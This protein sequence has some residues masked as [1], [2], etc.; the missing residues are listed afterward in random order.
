MEVLYVCLDGGWG[1]DGSSD[2]GILIVIL[3]GSR[4]LEKRCFNG[5][6][7]NVF[8]FEGRN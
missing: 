2:F 6:G 5:K 8:G 7:S 1:K 4:Y 3:R